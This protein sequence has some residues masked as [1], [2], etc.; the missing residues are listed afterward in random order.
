MIK[1]MMIN[2]LSETDDDTGQ[3]RSQFFEECDLLIADS[4][5]PFIKYLR[6]V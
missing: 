4:T 3:I 1:L 6:E 5:E 2:L